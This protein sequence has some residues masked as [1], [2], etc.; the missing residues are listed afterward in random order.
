MSDRLTG[1]SLTDPHLESDGYAQRFVRDYRCQC[2]S[3]LNV[4]PC[5]DKR[6][7]WY[8]KCPTHGII[9]DTMY[10]KRGAAERAEQNATYGQR[11]LRQPSGKTAAQILEEIGLT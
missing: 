7:Y 8:F 1:H 3:F 4:F 6:G 5:R 10:V 2:G 11:E 9:T